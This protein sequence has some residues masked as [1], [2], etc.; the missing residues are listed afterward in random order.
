MSN[1]QRFIDALE[2][3]AKEQLALIRAYRVYEGTNTEYRSKAKMALGVIG[4]YVRARATI[5]N[6]K[7]NDLIERRLALMGSGGDAPRLGDGK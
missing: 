6:E 4:S 1:N 3:E 2:D 5:A 7:S